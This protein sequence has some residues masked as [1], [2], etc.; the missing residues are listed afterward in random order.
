[1]KNI[2][3]KSI[4]LAFGILII[5]AFGFIFIT[6]NVASAAYGT[7]VPYRTGSGYYYEV[8]NPKPSVSS[9]Y[10]RSSNVGTGTKTITITGSG[11]VPSSIARV[12]GSNRP[13]TFID[14]SHLLVQINGNDTY[15][16]RANGGFFIT[17]FNGAPGGGYSNAAFLTI[18]TVSPTANTGNTNYSPDNFVD[19][20]YNNTSNVN[21]TNS[22]YTNNQTTTNDTA[23]SL[24]SNALFGT[25]SFMPSG[26]IQWVLFIIIILLIIIAVRKLFGANEEYHSS[27]M[28]HA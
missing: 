26:L 16:Y 7:T 15:T 19:T 5:L 11:F 21:N 23:S 2:N 18:N 8:N 3:N 1:M 25:N 14:A 13:T 10:P 4:I 20:N 28:K 9:I 27:P 12:N 24:T 17:V 6:S 22:N